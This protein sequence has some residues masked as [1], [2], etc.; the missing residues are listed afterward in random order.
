MYGMFK[1]KHFMKICFSARLKSRETALEIFKIVDDFI[2]ED[3]IKWSDCA[4]VCTDR[5]RVMAGNIQGLCALNSRHQK[6][7]GHTV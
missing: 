3:N 1:I 7:R 5:A 6:L 4:G 2:K